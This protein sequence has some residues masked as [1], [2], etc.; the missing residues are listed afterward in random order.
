MRALAC[1]SVCIV[2]CASHALRA[3]SGRA[4][5]VSPDERIVIALCDALSV[6]ALSR[7]CLHVCMCMSGEHTVNSGIYLAP[8]LPHT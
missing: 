5:N 6:D 2:R 3:Q 8:R 7:A 4:S 1:V